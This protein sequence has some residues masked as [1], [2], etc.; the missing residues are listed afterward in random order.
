MSYSAEVAADFRDALQDLKANKRLEISILT[1]IAKDNTEHAQ[2][3]SEELEKHIKTTRPEWKLPALYVLDS[4]VKNVGTPYTVYLGRNMFPTFMAAFQ[5]ADE[6]TRT[7]MENLLHSWKQPVP[8]SIDARPVFP[9]SV[10]QDIEK[11]LIRFRAINPQNPLPQR[12]PQGL[13]RSLPARPPT[14]GQMNPWNRTATPPQGRFPAPNDPRNRTGPTYPAAISPPIAIQPAPVAQQAL[15][16][17]TVDFNRLMADVNQLLLNCQTAH[18]LVPTDV[19]TKEK[20]DALK[21]LKGILESH[22]LPLHQLQKI[23][24]QIDN[25]A[26]PPTAQQVFINNPPP[27][28]PFAIP[29][30]QQFA[31]ATSTPDPALNLTQILF[32]NGVPWTTT[33]MAP[34]PSLATAPLA[35]P[36]APAPFTPP[37]QLSGPPLITPSLAQMLAQFCQPPA[38]PPVMAPTPA[39][40]AP[41]MPHAAP[42]AP[43]AGSAEWLLNA[44]KGLPPT[45]TP[46]SVQATPLSSEP[47][48]RQTSAT[49][50]AEV[51]LSSASMKRPRL[52][53]Y[54]K[55]YDAYPNLCR[56][57]GRR[58]TFT[59]EGKEKKARHMDWHFKVKDPD[60][61]KRGTH[62]SWYI[63]EKEWV[64]YDEVDETLPEQA[65]NGDGA[66]AVKKEAKDKYV[67]VPQDVALSQAPCPICQ[68]KFEHQWN[69]DANEFVW[70]DAV[71][72][73]GKI[74]HATCWE[75]YSRGSTLAAPSTPDSVLGKRKAEVSPAGLGKKGRVN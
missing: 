12:P 51:E 61:A 75:E 53:L 41:V 7:A 62:R 36:A 14:Q 6:E 9:S 67:P 65:S 1:G 45:G 69:V 38:T 23:R 8:D 63:D 27:A 73:N 2:A 39:S 29:A 56:T 50:N 70:M 11:F 25:M 34:T 17:Q 64:K 20:L 66:K 46:S 5:L 13:P 68:E 10:T 74:Y 52:N 58:F 35:N 31:P 47:M 22:S 48:T 30:F 72:V 57:C 24:E 37:P 44:L 40:H 33:P 18:A 3:I 60:A 15:P 26:P 71:K 59:T 21:G 43:V 4:I 49:A 16:T 55:L 42:S 28:P 19:D 32:P 54:T